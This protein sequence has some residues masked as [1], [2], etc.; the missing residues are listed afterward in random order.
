MA[1]EE[2]S[3]AGFVAPTR[4]II[5]HAFTMNTVSHVNYGLWRHPDDQTWRYNDVDYWTDLATTLDG[6]GFDCLFIADALGLLDVYGGNANASLARGVQSPLSDPLLLVSAMAAVTRNLGFGI[7]VSTTYEQPYLL[8]RKFTTLDHLTRGR[9]GWNIVTSQLASAARNL[10]L[11]GQ[12]PHDARYERADEFMEVVYKLWQA[13]WEDDAVQRDR[14]SA[15]H[16]NG[17]Y[18]DPAKVHPIRHA[19]RHFTV[20]DAH[21]SAPS[22]QRVPLLLQAGGSPT[23]QAFAARHA[24]VI[25]VAGADAQGVR[26]NVSRIRALAAE[27]GR[28]PSALRFVGA[29]SVVTGATDAEAEAKFAEYQAFYDVEGAIVHYA[30][31]TDIDFANH[32]LDEPVTYHERDSSRSLLRMFDDPESGRRW[33]LRDIFAPTGKIGRAPTL[34]G[35]PERVADALEAWLEETN[36]DGINLIHLVN[37][38]SFV[39]FG[40]WII[41]ELVRRGRRQGAPASSLR[42]RV[43][44]SGDRLPADHPASRYERATL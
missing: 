3:G 15:G 27:A 6:L 31:S 10:G 43:F 24:E 40:R 34:I 28:D 8:A 21:V 4:P 41:P 12:M 23:G 19:G 26:R 44:R 33:T 30:A 9:I 18:T 20:P 38:A 13:S 22:R 32:P 39:D 37:P 42:D 1:A 36:T 16:P 7:T 17:L 11:D 25:F 5:L 29:L 35:G 2:E 14:G